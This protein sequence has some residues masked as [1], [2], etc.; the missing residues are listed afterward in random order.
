M[1]DQF[2]LEKETTREKYSTQNADSLLNTKIHDLEKKLK[3]YE[4]NNQKDLISS[5]DKELSDQKLQYKNI[6]LELKVVIF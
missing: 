2:D 3:D 6:Q 1:I 5:M 4:S